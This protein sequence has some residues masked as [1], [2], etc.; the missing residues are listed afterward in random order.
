MTTTPDHIETATMKLQE[1]LFKQASKQ[2]TETGR[3]VPPVAVLLDMDLNTMVV[4]LY[5]LPK[6][7]WRPAI[8]TVITEFS[9][10]AVL[11][12]TEAWLASDELAEARAAGHIQSL[13]TVDEHG[14][15]T[16]IEGVREMLQVTA[17]T[18]GGMR[19]QMHGQIKNGRV[20]KAEVSDWSHGNATGRLV[21]FWEDLE[22]NGDVN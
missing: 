20:G 15:E 21:N 3:D 6:E 2:R 4:P 17:E 1:Y 7:I 13:T 14:V 22:L 8:I 19:R 16:P 18:A 10:F 9:C 11:L 12:L 5:Q